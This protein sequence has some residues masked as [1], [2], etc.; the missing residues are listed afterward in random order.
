MKV[1]IEGTW[2]EGDLSGPI[3]TQKDKRGT[4]REFLLIKDDAVFIKKLGLSKALTPEIFTHFTPPVP[5]VI[6]SKKGPK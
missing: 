5:R 2:K 4:M 6:P 1:I 3:L